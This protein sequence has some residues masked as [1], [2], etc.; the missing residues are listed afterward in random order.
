MHQNVHGYL[1]ERPAFLLAQW[2][3]AFRLSQRPGRFAVTRD[4]RL[5][6][7]RTSSGERLQ[8]TPPHTRHH[9]PPRSYSVPVHPCEPGLPGPSLRR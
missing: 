5:P 2:L 8:Y 1:S 6:S 4:F 3:Y 9:W 7:R